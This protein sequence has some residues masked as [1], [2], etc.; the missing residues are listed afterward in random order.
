MGFC[1]FN[2]NSSEFV[3]LNTSN[4]KYKVTKE[5]SKCHHF[6][7]R[8]KAQN[9]LDNDTQRIL[10][11]A[12][13][14][15]VSDAILKD[16][17]DKKT[18]EPDEKPKSKT[19]GTNDFGLYGIFVEEKEDIPEAVKHFIN[20]SQKIDMSLDDMEKLSHFKHFEADATLSESFEVPNIDIIGTIGQFEIFLKKMKSYADVLSKQ[21]TYIENCKLDFEHKIEFQSKELSYMKRAELLTNYTTCLE[22]RR[23]IKDDILILEKLLNSSIYDLIDG[24]LDE[25]FKSL[26]KRKYRPRVAP[27]L[28]ENNDTV[29]V[30]PKFKFDN[31][32]RD[33]VT[34]E[35]E[36]LNNSMNILDQNI[37]S[38]GMLGLI[39]DFTPLDDCGE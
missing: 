8:K 23:R 9:F 28:F 21:Y 37:F 3:E 14:K 38:G 6:K 32:E 18:T 17:Y 19:E 31:L 36:Q 20:A 4:C 13:W 27:E 12:G 16:L 25:F 1:V 2:E 22:E 24:T 7:V 30:K 29:Q 26:R 33:A 34:K 35:A 10:N 11:K 15:V 5:Y 39:S